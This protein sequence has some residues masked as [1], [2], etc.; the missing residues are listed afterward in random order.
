MFPSHIKN[1]CI[2]IRLAWNIF[3]KLDTHHHAMYVLVLFSWF[4]C[5]Q[6]YN[7]RTCSWCRETVYSLVLH[8]LYHGDLSTMVLMF[9]VHD[10]VML[11]LQHYLCSLFILSHLCKSSHLMF[12]TNSYQYIHFL[13]SHK[14]HKKLLNPHVLS[15]N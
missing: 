6:G 12:S 10:F 8:L 3:L 5:L 2:L 4:L 9:S 1:I 15:H 11:V 7:P 14:S 13:N